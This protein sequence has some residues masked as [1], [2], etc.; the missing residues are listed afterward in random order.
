ME[1]V[2]TE[3]LHQLQTGQVTELPG[4][5]YILIAVLTLFEGP[6]TTL[7]GAAAASAGF[8]NPALV[9]LSASTGNL[10][11]DIFW[12]SLGRAGKLDWF[13]RKGRRLG[14]NA[15]RLEWFKHNIQDHAPRIIFLTK[16]S[17]RFIIPSLISTGLARLSW[18]RWF[19]ALLSGEI[20]WTGSLI[21]LGYFAAQF[22]P[23][24]ASG[25]KVLPVFTILLF[26]FFIIITM[27]R[28]A[29]R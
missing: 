7:A 14:F 19:P 8:L 17:S 12:H 20:L 16:V 29:I 6:L 15:D 28:R 26:V 11:G 10:A 4:E 2:I 25:L 18:R 3:F 21:A 24:I 22:I 23:D 13:L 5:I 27:A 1:L 9:F